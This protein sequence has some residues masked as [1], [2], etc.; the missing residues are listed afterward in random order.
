MGNCQEKIILPFI[1]F[2]KKTNKKIK[3]KFTNLKKKKIF[4]YLLERRSIVIAIILIS[5]A[6]CAI[7]VVILFR[8]RG[9][10]DLYIYV[11]LYINIW[12]RVT[13]YSEMLVEKWDVLLLLLWLIRLV[14]L[15]LFILVFGIFFFVIRFLNE[16]LNSFFNKCRRINECLQVIAA[17][18]LAWRI[19]FALF[20]WFLRFVYDLVF[21]IR[22][23]DAGVAHNTATV[24]LAV[25]T[26]ARV[27]VNHFI[28]ESCYLMLLQCILSSFV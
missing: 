27:V 12:G 9:I 6:F 15:I 14:L 11:I 26:A 1:T 16:C 3:I 24:W 25:T 20:R 7:G 2:F 18:L 23:I 28:F 13:V 19:C 17:A 4:N 10:D 22:I 21:I 5:I 8:L